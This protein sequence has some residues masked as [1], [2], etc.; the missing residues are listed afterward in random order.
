MAYLQKLK[1][2]LARTAIHHGSSCHMTPL[3]L[4]GRSSDGYFF[5]G[6]VTLIVTGRLAI[7]TSVLGR[8]F[9]GGPACFKLGAQHRKLR[10]DVQSENR[11]VPRSNLHLQ[12]LVLRTQLFRSWATQ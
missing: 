8:S 2:S 5:G 1:S 6:S 12:F 10:T 9:A 4:L 11:V 7:E 3:G